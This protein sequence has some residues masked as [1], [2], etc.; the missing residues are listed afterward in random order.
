M[1]LNFVECAFEGPGQGGHKLPPDI[2]PIIKGLIE[3]AKALFTSITSHVVDW[4]F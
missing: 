4:K 3:I 1:K 2:Y